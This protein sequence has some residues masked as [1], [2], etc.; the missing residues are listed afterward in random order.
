[1]KAGSDDTKFSG[2]ASSILNFAKLGYAIQNLDDK[3]KPIF[4]IGMG[5]SVERSGGPLFYRKMLAQIVGDNATNRTIQGGEL[6]SFSTR[7]STIDKLK[8]EIAIS[9][10]KSVLS[11]KDIESFSNLSDALISKKYQSLYNDQQQRN[12]LNYLIQNTSLGFILDNFQAGSRYKRKILLN[13]NGELINSF[14]DLFNDTRAIDFQTTFALS[15]LHPEFLVFKDINEAQINSFC[16]TNQNPILD[17]YISAMLIL[18]RQTNTKFYKALNL[19]T[20]N[21]LY[22][23]FVSGVNNFTILTN[24]CFTK[25]NKQV[26][27]NLQQERYLDYSAKTENNIIKYL[28]MQKTAV[29]EY[30]NRLISFDSL[31]EKLF[32]LNYKIAKARNLLYLGVK[33]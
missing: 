8:N 13:Q 11:I 20:E 15:G 10:V 17:A 3:N 1:M 14:K 16:A 18:K 4:F 32:E 25:L 24:K 27:E 2:M 5:T 19:S 30:Q 12:N 31:K 22:K 26:I 7:E 29:K 23:S 21:D 33:N 9:Q 6:E 28:S